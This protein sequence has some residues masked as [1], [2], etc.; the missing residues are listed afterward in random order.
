MASQIRINTRLSANHNTCAYWNAHNLFVPERGEIIIYDDYY[1]FDSDGNPTRSTED[2]VS[3]QPRMKVGN[4]TVL[5]D[6]AFL[7]SYLQAKV[8]DHLNNS[9]AHVSD[10]DREFWDAK[11]NEQRVDNETLYYTTSRRDYYTYIKIN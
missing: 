1:M 5:G 2:A 6:I 10:N 4:G 8:E 3:Y 9:Y 11:L 7:D